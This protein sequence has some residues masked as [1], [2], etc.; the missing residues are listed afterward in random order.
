MI[1]ECPLCGKKFLS[2]GDMFKHFVIDHA[3]ITNNILRM[4]EN[5]EEKGF[6][7][8]YFVSCLNCFDAA[9]TNK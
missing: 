2:E 4:K 6:D 7:W 8:R 1:K 5:T 9:Y 3:K